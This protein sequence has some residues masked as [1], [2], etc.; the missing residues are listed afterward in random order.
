MSDM[1][2]TFDFLKEAKTFYLA[3]AEGDQP[4][5]RP[6]GAICVF[7]DKL[8]FQTGTKKKMSHQMAANPKVELCAM[9]GGRWIRLAATVVNDD[10]IEAKAFMLEQNPGLKRMYAADDDNTQVLYFKDAVGAIES[11]TEAPIPLKF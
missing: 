1:Q 7:E 10:R 8:Y 9:A 3:T 11:F 2:K 5:V 6:I 4:R